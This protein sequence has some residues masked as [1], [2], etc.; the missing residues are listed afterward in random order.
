MILCSGL[1]CLEA[2][3]GGLLGQKHENEG[4]VLGLA[5]GLLCDLGQSIRL[6]WAPNFYHKYP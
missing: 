6:F 5:T 2:G 1:S 4:A 3:H